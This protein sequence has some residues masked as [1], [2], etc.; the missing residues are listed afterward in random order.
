MHIRFFYN[1][2]SGQCAYI[3]ICMLNICI[4]EKKIFPQLFLTGKYSIY[5]LNLQNVKEL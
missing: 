4:V 2:T 1:Y 5:F 3:D